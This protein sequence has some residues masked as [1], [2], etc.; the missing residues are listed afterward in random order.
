MSKKPVIVN[1][2]DSLLIRIPMEFRRRGGRKVILTPEGLECAAPPAPPVYNVLVEAVARAHQW[3]EQLESG[4][5]ASISELATEAGV[6][7]AIVRRS[8][9]LTLLAPD[10]IEAILAGRE[11]SG[12]SI[13]KLTK[14]QIPVLWDEQREMLG[15]G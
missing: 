7:E 11:P 15:A 2:G 6:N 10:I 12:L 3:L 14:R 13:N 1:E 8:L 4:R 5:Y 9:Q